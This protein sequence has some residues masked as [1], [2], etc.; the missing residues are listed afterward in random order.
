MLELM[1]LGGI[2]TNDVLA[3]VE[4]QKAGER[5]ETKMLA[6]EKQFWKH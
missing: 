4:A 1:R 6:I 5:E 3:F 2:T